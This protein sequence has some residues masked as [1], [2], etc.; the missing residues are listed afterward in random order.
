MQLAERVRETQQPL[1]FLAV[2]LRVIVG[3]I[4]LQ[5]KLL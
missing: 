3:V 1:F 2:V 5:K 4:L